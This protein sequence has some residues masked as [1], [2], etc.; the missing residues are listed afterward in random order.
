MKAVILLWLALAGPALAQGPAFPGPGL[1][2]VT[3]STPSVSYIGHAESTAETQ[4]TTY[5]ICSS[6]CSTGGFYVCS[7]GALKNGGITVSSF[8]I[9]GQSAS[10]IVAESNTSGA[11]L[12]GVTTTPSG[13]LSVTIDLST[14]PSDNTEASCWLLQNLNSTTATATATSSTSGSAATLSSVSANGI[15]IGA[16]FS[17]AASGA[18][19]SWSGVTADWS[20]NASG[21]TYAAGAGHTHLGSSQSNYAVTATISSSPS[22]TA[23]AAASFR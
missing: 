7:S 9:N 3:S 12:W 19:V 6:G 16:V 2:G 17:N 15:V 14:T 8:T 18:T 13:S 10:K 23:V 4:N 1:G 11:E 5:T 22:D 20:V 21:S